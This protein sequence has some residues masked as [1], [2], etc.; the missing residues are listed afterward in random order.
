VGVVE[1]PLC[2]RYGQGKVAR[3]DERFADAVRAHKWYL[4]NGSSYAK[5]TGET[6]YL[7]R[8]ILALADVPIPGRIDHL[9]QDKLDC[10]LENLKPARP[11]VEPPGPILNPYPQEDDDR[12][13]YVSPAE[14]DRSERALRA[15]LIKRRSQLELRADAPLGPATGRIV[16]LTMEALTRTRAAWWSGLGEWDAHTITHPLLPP[17]IGPRPPRY[18]RPGD[19]W[20]DTSGLPHVVRE[21]G[22]ARGWGIVLDHVRPG[23]PRRALRSVLSTLLSD[24]EVRVR[25][26]RLTAL[27]A[28]IQLM[29]TNRMGPAGQNG[30]PAYLACATLAALLAAE[31][32]R[33][34]EVLADY[35]RTLS[36]PS[37]EAQAARGLTGSQRLA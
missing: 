33:V 37:A 27:N 35:R 15:Y 22:P 13:H 21:Y 17:H 11:S 19:L 12:R 3:V 34:V 28:D 4:S 30:R 31:T 14:L 7:S 24:V 18:P 20:H 32:Q 16:T 25:W 1:I 10:R 26:P 23:M 2:G 9:N 6:V 36:S 29:L 8:Y 5:I